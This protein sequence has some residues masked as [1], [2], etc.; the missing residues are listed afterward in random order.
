VRNS[1]AK[2]FSDRFETNMKP[3]FESEFAECTKN[4]S[5]NEVLFNCYIEWI[6]DFLLNLGIDTVK[7]VEGDYKY[8][9]FHNCP[10]LAEAGSSPMFCLICR[11][12][13]IRSFTW[14]SI[15]GNVEQI[16][17]MA[18]G[19]HGCDFEFRFSKD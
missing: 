18:D 9:K 15:R 7:T 2:S 13:V 4:S 3:K 19:S 8:L 1:I 11:A 16:A 12:M 6:S 5:S 14:T 10:W 17:C